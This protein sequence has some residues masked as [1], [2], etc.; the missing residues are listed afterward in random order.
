MALKFYADDFTEVGDQNY[1]T[2]TKISAQTW[3]EQNILAATDQCSDFKALGE[4]WFFVLL[5][6][7]KD[8]G[9][10]PAFTTG[11]DVE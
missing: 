2:H 8:N 7:D 6:K 11:E 3:T 9:K 1:L 5:L 10:K 4:D